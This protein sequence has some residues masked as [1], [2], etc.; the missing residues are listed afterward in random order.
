MYNTFEDFLNNS[1]KT[2]LPQIYEMVMGMAVA[3]VMFLE[4]GAYTK[5]HFSYILSDTIFKQVRNKVE[6]VFGKEELHHLTLRFKENNEGRLK[7]LM[8][9]FLDSI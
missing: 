3:N 1:P 9:N 7:G 2:D 5:S 6:E 4:D 8:N